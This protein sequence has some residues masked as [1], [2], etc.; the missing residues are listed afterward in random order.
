MKIIEILISIA[1]CNFG[2]ILGHLF[3]KYLYLRLSQKKWVEPVIMSLA[4][5][6]LGSFWVVEYIIKGSPL[7]G[8]FLAGIVLGPAIVWF[9][10]RILPF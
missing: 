7:M 6:I 3:V 10:R 8:F 4:I 1:I 5:I 2:M 9:H